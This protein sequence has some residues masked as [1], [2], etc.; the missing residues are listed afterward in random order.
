MTSPLRRN[1]L[2]QATLVC[3]VIG[4]G[5]LFL[6]DVPV[7]LTLGVVLLVAFVVLG[8]FTIATPA[9]LEGLGAGEATGTDRDAGGPDGPADEEGSASS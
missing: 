9:Y 6:F 7:T 8:L 4:G 2:L 3:L 1:R 5:L